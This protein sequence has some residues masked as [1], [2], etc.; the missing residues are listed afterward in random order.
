VTKAHAG[1]CLCGA[2]AF[3]VQDFDGPV[4]HCHCKMCRKFHG[5]EYATFASVSRRWFTWLRGQDAIAEYEASNGT[6]RT[7]CRH[8]GSS[9]FF[10][11]PRADPEIVEI[12][13]GTFDADVP[14][15]PD[16]HI[17]VASAANWTAI[18]DHLPQFPEGR[19]SVRAGG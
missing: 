2:V 1:S 6:V 16:A 19:G 5:A 10:R 14:V 15:R 9:L 12:A 13:L 18:E 7:F 8:C 4:A 11:S 17:F 3:E